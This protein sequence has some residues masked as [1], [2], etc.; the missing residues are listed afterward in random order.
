[1]SEREWIRLVVSSAGG[2]VGR[3][4]PTKGADGFLAFVPADEDNAHCWNPVHPCD[5]IV[6]VSMGSYGLTDIE[7]RERVRSYA[8]MLDDLCNGRKPL[9]ASWRCG[10]I[11][12]DLAR[13]QHVSGEARQDDI[14]FR[15]FPGATP[16]PPHRSA[17]RTG[18]VGLRIRSMRDSG[19]A[20]FLLSVTESG[21]AL[22][23]LGSLP[24]ESGLAEIRVADGITTISVGTIKT[25]SGPLHPKAEQLLRRDRPVAA[26]SISRDG[27]VCLIKACLVLT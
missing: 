5:Q 10:A 6:S 22:A 13:G 21:E 19:G 7:A 15:A 2:F 4:F 9:E 25:A 8:D 16:E 27:S 3:L 12:L 18:R 20:G 24:K 23:I 17:S 26:A 1:M 14:S 11:S